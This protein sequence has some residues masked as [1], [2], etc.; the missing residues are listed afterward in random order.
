[1]DAFIDGDIIVYHAGFAADK[2]SDE[3]VVSLSNARNMLLSKIKQIKSLF[4]IENVYLYLTSDDKSNF[5]YQIATTLPYKGNRSKA[6]K[7]IF[8]TEIRK[9]L[10]EKHNA[11]MVTGEEADDAIGRDAQNSL[12][13]SII[14]SSDKDL[15]MIPGWHWEMGD[16]A[17]YYVTELGYIYLEEHRS[18]VELFG[19]GYAWYCAQLLM[20]D[21][22]DNI[23]GLPGYGV[24]KTWEV[25]RRFKTKADLD[26]IVETEY[27]SAGL[28]DRLKEIRQLI[29]ISPT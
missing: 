23:P 7:P 28:T 27:A 12:N 15:R 11:I 2:D 1:M 29:W 22:A 3:L 21:R 17:P 19:T 5:R 10:V 4:L 6:H 26:K 20:G 8:Y 24:V 18:K 25:L 9:Y 13:E 16:R 14:L